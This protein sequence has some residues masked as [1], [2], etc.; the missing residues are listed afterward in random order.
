MNTK[1]KNFRRTYARNDDVITIGG[2]AAS[3]LT[4]MI[5]NVKQA[6]KANKSGSTRVRKSH[7]NALVL[8]WK[9]EKI[10]L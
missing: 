6:K 9:G 8:A 10:Q 5:V 3:C 1:N 2:G 7:I 4:A